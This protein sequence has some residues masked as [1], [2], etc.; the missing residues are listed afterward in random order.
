M[1]TNILRLLV[2]DADPDSEQGAKDDSR[3]Q[4]NQVRPEQGDAVEGSAFHGGADDEAAFHRRYRDER[5]KTGGPQHATTADVPVQG[6]TKCSRDRHHRRG[7][8]RHAK[9][10]T[11]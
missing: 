7:S 11:S 8:C 6:T 5:S 1:V 9:G 3:G 10:V 4:T 2:S